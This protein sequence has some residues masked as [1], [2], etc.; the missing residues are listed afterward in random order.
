MGPSRITRTGLAV[1]AIV[2]MLACAENMSSPTS[3]RVP[4]TPSFGLFLPP[5]GSPTRSL[6][7]ERIEVCKDYVMHPQSGN[8]APAV[9]NFTVNGPGTTDGN[10]QLAPGQCKEFWAGN[11]ETVSI[12][13]ETLAGFTQTCTRTTFA[14]TGPCTTNTSVTDAYVDGEPDAG[15]LIIFTN[16]E[17]F[18][19]P[20][21]CTYTQGYWKTHSSYGPAGPEDDGWDNVGGPDAAFFSSGLTWYQLFWTPV[22]GRKYVSLAHQYMA[23]KLNVENG[24]ASTAAVDAALAAAEAWFPGKSLTAVP[25]DNTWQSTFAAYNEGLTGPGHCDDETTS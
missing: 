12:V 7:A 23:A 15:E 17:I 9:T 10:A 1:G 25:P 14:G 3:V 22:K 16:T 8:S 11:E 24:T 4:S 18:T 20:T 13:E 2:A 21:G 5:G 6:E 19:P